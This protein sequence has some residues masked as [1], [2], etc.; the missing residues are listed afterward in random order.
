MVYIYLCKACEDG[1]HG[2][3]ELGHPCP[4]GQYGGSLCRCPCKRNPEY[5]NTKFIAEELRQLI[6]S[7]QDFQ[8]AAKEVPPMEINCPPKKIELKKIDKD[9]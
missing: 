3:C 6:K 4:P 1:R 8:K 7:M 5:N 2:D 9:S